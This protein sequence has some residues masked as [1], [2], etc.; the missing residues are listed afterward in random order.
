MSWAIALLALAHLAGL[1][2]LI[3]GYLLISNHFAQRDAV[4]F[5]LQ[6]WEENDY[7]IER[8]GG[9]IDVVLPYGKQRR[10]IALDFDGNLKS[11]IQWHNST[12]VSSRPGRRVKRIIEPITREMAVMFKL[13]DDNV[14][15]YDDGLGNSVGP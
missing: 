14:S 2:A 12:G 5:F 8:R 7:T 9:G 10:R 1:Y 6:S 15:G 3:W 11:G 4:K 13:T